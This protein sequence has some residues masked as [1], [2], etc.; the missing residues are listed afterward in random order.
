M[1]EG[2]WERSSPFADGQVGAS[3]RKGPLARDHTLLAD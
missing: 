1:L 3:S 2:G